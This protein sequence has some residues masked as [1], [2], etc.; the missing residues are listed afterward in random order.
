[1]AF[2]HFQVNVTIQMCEQHGR[3]EL[4]AEYCNTATRVRLSLQAACFNTYAGGWRLEER[5]LTSQSPSS[6]RSY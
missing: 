3:A 2:N 1:M 6:F 5:E 4:S